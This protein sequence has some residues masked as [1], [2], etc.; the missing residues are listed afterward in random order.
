M[1]K[2]HLFI[3][4][5]FFIIGFYSCK[6]DDG[7]ITVKVEFIASGHSEAGIEFYSW[8]FDFNPNEPT[9]KAEVLLD[10]E[11]KQV[12]KFKPGLH[13][14]AV[15]VIDNDGLENTEIIKLKVNGELQRL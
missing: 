3:F 7:L 9:F 11:G 12:Y 15:K 4:I 2:P 13:H 8:D 14:I 6:K 1:A 5:S 10:T